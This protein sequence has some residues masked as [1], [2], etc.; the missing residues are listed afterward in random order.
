MANTVSSPRSKYSSDD[1]ISL[2]RVVTDITG[3]G[4]LSHHVGSKGLLERG[5]TEETTAK[6]PNKATLLVI[7]LYRQPRIR[8]Q[9]EAGLELA[10]SHGNGT[11]TKPTWLEPRCVAAEVAGLHSTALTEAPMI[12]QP[13]LTRL[14][15]TDFPK[16]TDHGPSTKP[17]WLRDWL[18]STKPQTQ[19]KT[20]LRSNAELSG[21]GH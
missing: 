5:A 11:R 10:T 12:R 13:K 18:N 14:P 9:T 1:S 20:I 2:S 8:G 7:L 6:K 15:F 21:A 17:A 16:A 3:N 4:A 19:H